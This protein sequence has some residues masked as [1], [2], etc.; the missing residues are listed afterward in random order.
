VT[1]T[2]PH[3][4]VEF[5]KKHPSPA[6]RSVAGEGC[7]LPNPQ[8]NAKTLLQPGNIFRKLLQPGISA[9]I[10]IGIIQGYDLCQYAKHDYGTHRDQN[11]FLWHIYLHDRRPSFFTG[12]LQFLFF[13]LRRLFGHSRARMRNMERKLRLWRIMIRVNRKV[14]S[15]TASASQNR[16]G[17]IDECLELF[18]IVQIQR[19]C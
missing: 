1:N 2:Y 12:N 7:F 16:L 19:V 13:C 14:Q 8:Q 9:W 6:T 17:D 18:Q 11:S 15:K 3:S 10:G 4:A 5:G